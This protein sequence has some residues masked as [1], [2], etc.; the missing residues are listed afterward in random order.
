M[1]AACAA[2]AA[3]GCGS[4]SRGADAMDRVRNPRLSEPARAK[5]IDEAW[6]RVLAGELER[7]PTREELKTLAWSA[8]WPESLRVR[9]LKV[10]LSDPD[11]AGAADSRQLVRLMLPREQSLA[12]IRVL[13][14]AAVEHGWDNTVPA[15]VRSLSRFDEGT[16]DAQRPEHKAI[17]ALRPGATVPQT[18][19]E[20][21]IDPPRGETGYGADTP[22]RVRIDA[23][24]VLAR[25]D[26]NGEMRAAMIVGGG[27]ADDAQIAALRSA[28]DDLHT[29]PRVGE[30]LSWLWSLRDTADR[31]N[32]AW[33]AEAAG[34]IRPLYEDR[35]RMLELRHAE[36]IR[37][38][39]RARPDWLKSTR[40][41]LLSALEDRLRGRELFRRTERDRDEP[42]RRESLPEQASKL[43]WGDL[44]TILAVDEAL[45]QPEVV[46]TLLAQA[47]LDRE[48]KSAEYGGVL[49]TWA[50][51]AGASRSAGAA[52][53]RVVLYPPRPG[54]RRG[55]RE[56]V[57]ST[58]MV[59]QSDRSLA[60]YHFH[61]QQAR[62]GSYAGPSNAD[63]QYAARLGRT[64]LVFTSVS[65]DVLDAD[66]YQP[67][68]VI[69]DL[70]AIRR[71]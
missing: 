37:W 29:L 30:E 54:Q 21:F 13:S 71:P 62:N 49:E 11:P 63:L 24:D 41:E 35:A 59:G 46:R 39:A 4:G 16:P 47:D 43:E 61:A 22:D 2:A 26:A 52:A 8:S 70:G 25:L 7:G 19:L 69:I 53:F 55:D 28:M 5:A 67:D 33:W 42:V 6:G 48:D 3:A 45:R 1:L 17:A 64:C 40:A 34:V 44:I 57:A 51:A 50:D 18:V 56:F 32:A 66:L 14:E 10:L 23:W 65:S 20:V 15:L 58:D 60:H 9:T 36:A 27:Q 38:S 12:V 31:R 68:G